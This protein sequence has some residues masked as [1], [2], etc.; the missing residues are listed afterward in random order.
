M[1][2]AMSFRGFGRSIAIGLGK[3]EPASRAEDIAGKKEVQLWAQTNSKWNQGRGDWPVILCL[4]VV[5]YDCVLLPSFRDA[6]TYSGRRE[7]VRGSLCLESMVCQRFLLTVFIGQQVRITN[8]LSLLERKRNV[9]RQARRVGQELEPR[10]IEQVRGDGAR[11]ARPLGNC[12]Y[13][14]NSLVPNNVPQ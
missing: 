7:S 10:D 2:Y 5:S 13:H 4:V 9:R 3:W 8:P 1:H 12:P 11:K 6:C 14:R